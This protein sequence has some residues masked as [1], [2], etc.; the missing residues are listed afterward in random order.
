LIRERIKIFLNNLNY[1]EIVGEA[2]DGLELIQLIQD[3]KPDFVI[4]DIRMHEMNG[5]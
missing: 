1:V 2:V 3:K 5:I 4:L